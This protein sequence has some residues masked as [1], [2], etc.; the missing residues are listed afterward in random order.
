M[1]IR[2][3]NTLSGKRESFEPDDPARVTMYVCGPTVYNRIHIGNARPIV[4][5]DTLFRLLRLHYADVIYARNITDIDDKIINAAAESG[6][7]VTEVASRYTKAFHDDI[8]KLNA[9]KPTIEPKATDH[10][11]QMIAMITRL[12]ESGHAYEA[13]RH[14]L[15][16]VASMADYGSL[17]KRNRDDMIA[18]ARV[19]V[20]PYKKD[21]MDFV[22]WKPSSQQ[23]PSWDSPWGQGRPGWHLECSAMVRAHL[24]ETIDIHGGGQD[25]VFPHHENE[26][27]QSRCSHGCEYFSRYWVHNGYITMDGEKMAKSLGNFTMLNDVL[28]R[29]HG[30]TI[31]LALL[32]THY[33]KP[34]D[35]S[36]HNLEEAKLTLDKWYRNLLDGG[37]RRDEKR[38]E[39]TPDHSMLKALC[40][41]LNTPQAIAA[42]HELSGD[43]DAL[44]ASAALLGLL[45]EAPDAWF[46]WTPDTDDALEEE[47]IE[48]LIR[49][50]GQ[51]RADKDFDVA[52]QIRAKLGEAGVILEDRNGHTRWRRDVIRDSR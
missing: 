17:S 5:F 24:G 36:L 34:L 9:L 29:F 10:I 1:N 16:E 2:L 14:V 19:E 31:R 46:K 35:W 26:I 18:G 12:I 6:T 41:D 28:D 40:D 37:R 20:A 4:V 50:R 32:S 47:Q 44:R 15:F 27:A 33:R 52:D 51:A 21:P 49:E 8:A 39:I 22:L 45:R 11:P 30:E 48:M 43:T 25:L 38:G 23:Q 42:I 7:S 3:F 13:G